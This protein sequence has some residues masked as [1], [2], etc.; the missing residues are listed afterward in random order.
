[1]WDLPVRMAGGVMSDLQDE[2]EM[3]A[4]QAAEERRQLDFDDL[5]NESAGRETGRMARFLSADTR[6]ARAGRGK[7]SDKTSEH[8][9]RLQQLLASNPAYAALYHETFDKLRAAEAA[10]EAALQ[11]LQARRTQLEAAREDMLA[12]AA[13]L[14]DGTAVFRDEHGRVWSA[15]GEEIGGHA[16]EAIV[17]PEDAP[18]YEAFSETGHALGNAAQKTEALRGYQV[19]VLGHVRERMRDEDEP[20]SVDEL[21]DFQVILNERMPDIGNTGKLNVTPQADP[22]ATAKLDIPE[23]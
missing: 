17:W 21:K 10:T 12:R 18:A 15:E 4:R 20:P 22:A 2:F 23:L 5:Q 3:R 11:A 7:G 6:E 1:M 14:P 8:L 16:L 19:E 9:S 13:R